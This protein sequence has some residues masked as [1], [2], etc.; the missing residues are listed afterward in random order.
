MSCRLLEGRG[1]SLRG[2]SLGERIAT[3]ACDFSEMSG[4]DACLLRRSEFQAAQPHVSA[5]AAHDSAKQPAPRLR[6]IDNEIQSITIGISAWLF[7]VPDMSR[8]ECLIWM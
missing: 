1:D 3:V 8:E 5:L 2:P 6:W 7:Q 4:L